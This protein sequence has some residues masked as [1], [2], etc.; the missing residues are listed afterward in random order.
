MSQNMFA[1][2]LILAA[3]VIAYL[4]YYEADR[5]TIGVLGLFFS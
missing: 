1:D 3:D 2:L 4:F 5:P